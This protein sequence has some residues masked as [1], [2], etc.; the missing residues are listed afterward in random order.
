[1]FI[2]DNSD[3]M[4]EHQAFL[5]VYMNGSTDV[6]YG[7]DYMKEAFPKLEQ[8]SMDAM[9]K[10]LQ[11]KDKSR[12][13]VYPYTVNIP[14]PITEILNTNDFSPL[15]SFVVKEPFKGPVSDV[16]FGRTTDGVNLRCGYVNGDS[17]KIDAHALNDSTVHGFVA[18]ATGQG[19]SVTMNSIIYCACAEYPPWEL[20]LT[21]SDAK[22][23]EFKSIALKHPMP[24]IDI[25]AATS[26]TDYLLSMLHMKYT[27][28]MQRQDLF[29]RAG[30]VFGKEVK[31]IKQ[32]RKVTGLTLPRNVLLFDE[33]T[34]MFQIAGKRSGK[35]VEYLDQFARLG[36]NAGM[37]LLMDS[38]EVSSDLPE[39]TMAN[40]TL[41]GAM[42]CTEPISEKVIGNSAAALN[43]GKK[44]RL[45]IN[46]ARVTKNEDKNVLVQ[47]PF[48]ADDQLGTVSSSVIELG[49]QT[50]TAN[51]LRFFDEGF[52]LYNDEYVKFINSFKPDPN[53]ILL[54]PPSF[55]MDGPEQ[56]VSIELTPSNIDN[57]CVI[58]NKAQTKQ[59]AAKMLQINFERTKAQ[60]FVL[61]VDPLFEQDG[62]LSS[63]KPVMTFDDRSYET[64]D[65]FKVARS[66]IYT[67]LL[68]IKADKIVFTTPKT[69]DAI[70]EIFYKNFEHGSKYDSYTNRCRFNQ[71]ITLLQQDAELLNGF[72]MKS[73]DDFERKVK[74]TRKVIVQCN[75]MFG[76]ATTQVTPDKLPNAWFWLLG[77]ERLLG[78][79]RDTKTKNV[80]AFK[81]LML[82]ST[83]VNVRFI[84]FTTE[85]EDTKSLLPG[86]GYFLADDL[87]QKQI[88]QIKAADDYPPNLSSG[89]MV[90]FNPTVQAVIQSDDKKSSNGEKRV[91]KEVSKIQKF[92]KLMMKGEL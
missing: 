35:I 55:I 56:V 90:L 71:C 91:Q 36:R 79:G 70:D 20:T 13:S 59:R 25:I 46:T 57:I 84:V 63:L 30:E 92:K 66:A 89:L 43:M 32:F 88:Q 14:R 67:R 11:K 1:M 5:S 9:L 40:L 29:A 8:R 12:T 7:M 21:L 73:D 83:F 62:G 68:C 65:F 10:E 4:E 34:A 18:G 51:T 19:K 39:K 47:V 38:Q 85:F 37:H 31:N 45:I 69:A 44:G 75:D 64:S 26:D 61:Y 48:F 76:C 3:I 15:K 16:W 2:L 24:Q 28:M 82:S 58:A 33:C 6:L 22:I 54:G 53:R 41:R 50:G 27:E 78:I 49:K 86:F 42:G 81:S 17:R 80:E 23:V 60:H 72:G 77:M 74:L 52:K 87:Q